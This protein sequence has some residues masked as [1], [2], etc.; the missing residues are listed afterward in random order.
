M[1][2]LSKGNL[3]FIRPQYSYWAAYALLFVL[4]TLLIAGS[5]ALSLSM[6]EPAHI[7]A[8]YVY[9]SRWEEAGWHFLSYLHPPLINI[10]EAI[11]LFLTQPEI[12]LEKLAGWGSEYAT[13]TQSFLPYLVPIERTEILGRTPVMLMTT[14]LGAL[15]F[16]WGKEIGGRW[17]GLLALTILTFDPTLVASGRLATTDL[18]VTALGM[19][20]LYVGWRWLKRPS[21]QYTFLIG[22]LLGLTMLAKMSGILWSAAFGLI[23]LRSMIVDQRCRRRLRFYQ[24]IVAGLLAGIVVWAVFDFS[25]G[26]SPLLPFPVPAPAYLTAFHNL[27]AEAA[28]RIFVAFE[29]IWTGTHWWYFP[30]NFL[31][32]NPLPLLAALL[33]GGWSVIH[34]VA[35]RLNLLTL[36][37]F[38]CVYLLFSVLGGMNVSY[39]HMLPLHPFLH[40][41]IAQGLIS[42]IRQQRSHPWAQL[43]WGAMGLWYIFGTLNV[44]PDELAFFNELVG[45]PNNGYRYLTDYT[46]D[47]GQS[48]KELRNYLRASPGPEP[49]IVHFTPIHPGFYGV[50]FRPLFPT[51]G[52]TQKA[53]PF[54]PQSG[55]Y[56]IGVAPLYGL[57]GPDPLQLEWFRRA[58]PTAIVGH[59]LFVYDVISQPLWLS[60]CVT[61]VIPLDDTAILQG[62]GLGQ[63]MDSNLRQANFDCMEAWLYPGNGEQ[64]GIYALHH[65]LLEEQSRCLTPLLRCDPL[66]E[67]PFIARRLS[68]A[69]LS[70]EQRDFSLLPAF[71]L[72]ERE[73]DRVNAPPLLWMNAAH[74]ETQPAALVNGRSITIPVSMNGPLVFLGAMSFNESDGLEVETWW[75]VAEG[76]ISRPF[77]IMAHLLTEQGEVISVADGLGVSPQVLETSDVV[78]QRHRFSNLPPSRKGLWLRTGAYWLDTM[79]RWAISNVPGSDALFVRLDSRT[80]H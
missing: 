58:R 27:Q 62:F 23:A 22:G 65:D 67:D 25:I 29:Q 28:P 3:P 7:V 20:A 15:V 6:D 54:H 57:V 45:G 43:V 33:V 49:N 11:G 40:L 4:W 80:T 59:G 5:R 1:I 41:V 74:A 79:E 68:G 78:I 71:A 46:Q 64:R 36:G 47:W 13:Y 32:K 17:V 14:L 60:Q 63:L 10:V 39:R 30:L 44:F 70:Y 50:T 61:P 26:L 55:R 38:S 53:A 9:L 76:T 19:A 42:W 24:A 48:F 69:R 73:T 21:W 37:S 34:Q 18:G 72:Y 12:P 2:K 75:Q 31:I 16:R 66:P 77:S 56:V 52:A 51:A 8:G 35:A